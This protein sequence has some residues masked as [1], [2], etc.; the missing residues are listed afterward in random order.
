[1]AYQLWINDEAKAE[2]RKL[3][4]HV[5]QRIRRAI[6]ELRLNPR[7]HYSRQMKLPEGTELEVRRLRLEQ[8]R[9]IY[10]IDEAWTEVGVLAVRKRPPYD[11][12]DL[13]A[14]LADLD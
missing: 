3:P 4:G 7:P 2:V 13:E 1:M 11:Y 6:T 14:L 9:V 12:E 8:W 10:V 5:R